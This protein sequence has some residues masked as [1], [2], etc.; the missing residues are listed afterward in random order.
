[1]P[2]VVLIFKI[3]MDQDQKENLLMVLM[4]WMKLIQIIAGEVGD[5]EWTVAK[6][7][8]QM[9]VSSNFLLSLTITWTL[10][11]QVK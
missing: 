6:F 7:V 4:E 10:M 5:L 1:M 8:K 9:E 3:Y 2:T 11:K